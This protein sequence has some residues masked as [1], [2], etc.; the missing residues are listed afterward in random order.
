MIDT[1]IHDREV[2]SSKIQANAA[3]PCLCNSNGCRSAHDTIPFDSLLHSCQALLLLLH[4]LLLNEHSLGN[5]QPPLRRRLELE[6]VDA[7]GLERLELD[8]AVLLRVVARKV[9]RLPHSNGRVRDDACLA[10]VVHRRRVVHERVH[11]DDITDL[12]G[13]VS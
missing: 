12:A 3:K 4:H 10:E 9:E 1:K 7:E 8:E 6:A 11:E 2:T 5:D 13:V